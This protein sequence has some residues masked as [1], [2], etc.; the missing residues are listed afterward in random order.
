MLY[1]SWEAPL[2]FA[3]STEPYIQFVSI[4]PPAGSIGYAKDAASAVSIT[5]SS[6]PSVKDE[7]GRLADTSEV[8]IF[9]PAYYAAGTYTV[10]ATY[11]V[12]P[13]IEDDG[14]TAHLN[15]K[16]AGSDHIP[17]NDIRI[18]VPADG[19]NQIY[20]YPPLFIQKRPGILTRSP[21]VLRETRTS[22]LKCLPVK[23]GLPRSRDSGPMQQICR[24]KLLLQT[25]GTTC[26]TQ[27]PC[28]WDTS[29][30]RPYS[31]CRSFCSLSITTTGGRKSSPLRPT[32]STVP[33]PA[34]KPWQVN[35]LFKGDALDFDQDGYYATLLDLH[36]R[37]LISITPS[38]GGN[39]PEI[40]IL[41]TETTDPYEQRV[42]AFVGRLSENNVLSTSTA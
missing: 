11:I 24:Q 36:R 32:L 3:G 7:I 1:R 39:G 34:L 17:Y 22:R 25:S 41:S 8:G 9:N 20:V 5:G 37:K 27:W 14:T 16:F 38:A 29:R 10:Q 12:H 33:N 35:L 40:R 26:P 28:S 15:F 18:T 4:D 23:V 42:L 30:K 13:P 2:V 19:V 31:W 21:A 6:D